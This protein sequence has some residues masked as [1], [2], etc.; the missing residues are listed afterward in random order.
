[1]A[2]TTFT[3]D[4]LFEAKSP[5]VRAVYERILDE[6]SRIG[7]FTEELRKT[8][9]HLVH[10][11]AFAGVHPRK[12]HLILTLRTDRPI[13][14]PRV[15][16]SEHVS[17]NRWHIEIKLFDPSEVDANIVDWLRLAIELV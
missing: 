5:Q 2:D 6:S 1:M 15:H 8:S 16:R 3:V 11:V 4:A 12:G 7:P 17:A 14:H 10:S 13:E 9:V